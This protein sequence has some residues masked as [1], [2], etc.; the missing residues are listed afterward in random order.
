MEIYVYACAMS[1]QV[2]LFRVLS[3]NDVLRRSM[4]GGVV[5]VL[6]VVA[7]GEQQSRP[8]DCFADWNTKHTDVKVVGVIQRIDISTNF[9]AMKISAHDPGMLSDYIDVG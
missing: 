3:K 6:T 9:S 4:N 2:I 7:I 5:Y 8:C 1:R